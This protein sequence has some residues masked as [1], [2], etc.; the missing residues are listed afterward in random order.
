LMQ[1]HERKLDSSLVKPSYI[2]INNFVLGVK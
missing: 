1:K 2:F